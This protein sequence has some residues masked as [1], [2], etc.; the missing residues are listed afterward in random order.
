M[1]EFNFDFAIDTK[2]MATV[3]VN[4]QG[5]IFS[6][7][8]IKQ[9]GEPKKVMIGIDEGNVILGIRKSDSSICGKAFNFCTTEQAKKWVRVISKPIAKKIAEITQIDS[10]KTTTFLAQYDSESEMLLVDLKQHNGG[11]VNEHC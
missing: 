4:A 10:D 3:K 6:K 9:L 8:A 11:R 5:L 1:I 7:E 2:N